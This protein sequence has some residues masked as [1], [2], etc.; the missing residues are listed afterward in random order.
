MLKPEF[1]LGP[2]DLSAASFSTRTAQNVLK[3]MS[4]ARCIFMNIKKQDNLPE[5]GLFVPSSNKCVKFVWSDI[6]EEDL[7]SITFN[8]E[9][10]A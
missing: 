3:Y 5:I 7:F 1:N 10:T 4:I 9:T 2:I 8:K 6:Q